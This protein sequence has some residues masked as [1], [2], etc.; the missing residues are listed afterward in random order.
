MDD[1]VQA[2][3]AS[4]HAL[5]S[6]FGGKHN[7]F[8]ACFH[9][10]QR[11]VVTPAFAGVELEGAGL[12]AVEDYFNFQLARADA[13]GLPGPG[14]LVSNTMTEKGPHDP[15]VMAYVQAHNARIRTGFL[16]VL[17]IENAKY[18]MRTPMELETLA[19]ML[20][21]FT[22]GLWAFSRTVTDA[23]PLRSSVQTCLDLIER[24]LTK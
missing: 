14:C 13:L 24:S 19:E 21:I 7:L 23:T 17:T 2:T 20:M 5:Y 16:R 15:E 18:Q 9:A 12:N 11:D 3:G 22:Q 6:E 4:R 1:L 10:Y 8:I